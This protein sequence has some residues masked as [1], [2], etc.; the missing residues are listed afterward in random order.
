MRQAGPSANA[1]T[2]HARASTVVIGGLLTSRRR[3]AWTSNA[4]RDLS[5]TPPPGTTLRSKGSTAAESVKLDTAGQAYRAGVLTAGERKARRATGS[6]AGARARTGT[7]LVS[8]RDFKSLA[9]AN[10]AT[11]A[12]RE[13]GS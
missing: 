13:K 6:G 8:P 7:G 3:T 2:S 4:Q 5:D 9:S 1:R 12:C 11:P 10:S